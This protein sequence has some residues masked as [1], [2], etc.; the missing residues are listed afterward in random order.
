MWIAYAAPRKVCDVDESVNTF[1]EFN[2]DTEVSEVANLSGV[3]A[4]NRI[5]N[6]DGLPWVFLKLLDAERHLALLAVESEDNCLYLV[7]NVH[8]FLCAAEVLA[9][10]HF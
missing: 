6:L 2:E 5:L 10:R 7:A 9:P 1:L 8:E 3:L 4:A